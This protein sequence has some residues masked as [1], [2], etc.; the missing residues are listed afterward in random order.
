M[1]VERKSWLIKAGGS[2]RTVAVRIAQ[3]LGVKRYGGQRVTAGTIIIR[4][5]IDLLYT[6]ELML[7]ACELYLFATEDGVVAFISI[8]D[9]KET[10]L[11]VTVASQNS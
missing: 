6:L 3:Y 10:N 7:V 4:Q 8:K 11:F 2:S 9:L 1:Q 5:R